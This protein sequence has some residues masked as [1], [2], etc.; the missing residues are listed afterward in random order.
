MVG[1]FLQGAISNV[2]YQIVLPFVGLDLLAVDA[3]VLAEGYTTVSDE[4]SKV[5]APLM[6]GGAGAISQ[7][8]TTRVLSDNRS[9]ALMDSVQGALIHP[10]SQY[11]ATSLKLK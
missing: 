11:A 2:L 1:G 8:V 7:V 10:A 5:Q 6:L 3:Y 9:G 4:L